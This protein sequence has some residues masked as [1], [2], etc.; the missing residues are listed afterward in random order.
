MPT[1]TLH[2]QRLHT[3]THHI[4]TTGHPLAYHILLHAP[5]QPPGAIPARSPHAP[6]HSAQRVSRPTSLVY[7]WSPHHHLT[8]FA[9]PSRRREPHQVGRPAIRTLSPPPSAPSSRRAATPN[10]RP[11]RRDRP[12]Q[13]VR[14][15]PAL[16]GGGPF[17]VKN[18]RTLPKVRDSW[19]QLHRRRSRPHACGGEPAPT[20]G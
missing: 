1:S 15:R 20:G 5:H 17:A 16:A 14:L 2:P 10:R 8:N 13:G 4:Q 9:Q 6:P 18:L 12:W 3:I 11:A 7:K 19:S